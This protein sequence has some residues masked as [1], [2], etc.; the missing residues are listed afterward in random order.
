VARRGDLCQRTDPGKTRASAVGSGAG[1][2]STGHLGDAA[3]AGRQPGRVGQGSAR[4]GH[5]DLVAVV[6]DGIE[7]VLDDRYGGEAPYVLVLG[8]VGR[9]QVFVAVQG[10]GQ[11]FGGDRQP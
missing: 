1:Q 8:Q 7:P 11:F 10:G 3:A 2:D 6:L 5:Q 9:A 4:L